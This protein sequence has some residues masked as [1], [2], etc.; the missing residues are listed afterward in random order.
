M[1]IECPIP[2][3][4]YPQITMAHGGGGRHMRE[5]IEQIFLKSFSSQ[6]NSHDSAVM[7]LKKY[8]SPQKSSLPPKLAFTTDSFVVRP[9]FFPGG[10]IGSLS[11]HGTLNDLA[12]SGARPLWLSVGFVL[13]EGL[14]LEN[15]WKIV[16][17]MAESAKNAGVEIVTGDTKVV[18]KG[19]GDGIYI[20]TSGVG[21]IEHDLYIH[22]QSIKTG[23]VIL[24]S[25]DLGRH[26]VAVLSMR[27]GLSFE[28]DIKSDSADLSKIVQSLIHEGI[29]VHVLRDCT[30][31]GLATVLY[32]L[33]EASGTTFEIQEKSIPVLAE[34]Q[35]ACEMLGLDPMYVANEGCFA[36]VLPAAEAKRALDILKKFPETQSASII[37][38]VLPQG[39]SPLVLENQFGVRR[40]VPLLTGEQLPRIC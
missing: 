24:V 12:M 27:E 13:E 32:E 28:S 35:G 2:F 17:S 22:A 36:A 25:G 19:H 38:R 18:E 8:L 3:S 37:G 39:P 9:L 23:D 6:L 7:D 20:N 15:L 16:L 21:I 31:G 11:V 5:L 4:R 33:A 26:G 1:T 29:Q 10:N 14:P 30:R 34:V 40:I